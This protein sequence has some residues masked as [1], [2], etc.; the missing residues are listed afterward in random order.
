MCREIYKVPRISLYSREVAPLNRVR[1]RR[2][3]GG[4]RTHA[5]CLEGRGSTTELHPRY[6]SLVH[7]ARIGPQ[8]ATSSPSIAARAGDRYSTRFSL[9]RSTPARVEPS[10][11][12]EST[13]VEQDSNLRRQCHQIYSL[14]PLAAWVSTRPG[15]STSLAV[16]AGRSRRRVD[17]LAPSE[18]AVRLELT[19]YGLQNRCSAG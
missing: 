12:G 17:Q 3:G 13:W 9:K 8:G 15:S 16:G 10:L 2:A 11:P 6:S 19:T 18:L 14:A 7:P 5:A 4:N 1:S